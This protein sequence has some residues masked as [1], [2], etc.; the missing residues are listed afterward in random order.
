MKNWILI[1]MF[2]CPLLIKA[3][4]AATPPIGS[5]KY[6]D[7][8]R[9]YKSIKLGSEIST[10][11]SKYLIK[12]SE[13]ADDQGRYMYSYNNPEALNFGNNVQLKRIQIKSYLDKIAAIYLIFEQEDGNKI[14]EV[15]TTA[16]GSDYNQ[17]DETKDTYLWRGS[18]ADVYLTYERESLSAM[19]YS[20]VIIDKFIKR[21][22]KSDANQAASDL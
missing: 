6:L 17:S 18:F 12:Q 15:L 1:F 8:K 14:K 16:Y 4:S 7:Y 19:I 5:I 9:S 21:R 22:V 2:I 20:D 11:N 13:K 3:Q 10:L